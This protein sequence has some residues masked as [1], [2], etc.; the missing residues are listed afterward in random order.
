MS[1]RKMLMVYCYD[2]QSP[3]TRGR[4]ADLL[5]ARAA[6]VQD[7]VFEARLSEREAERLF[8]AITAQLDPGDLL[9]MYAIAQSGR[10]RCHVWGGVPLAEDGDYW[11]I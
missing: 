4:I 3:R 5:E 1:S 2:I 11:L 8:A 7:S 6:R 10:A 9:R